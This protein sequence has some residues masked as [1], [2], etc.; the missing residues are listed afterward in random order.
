MARCKICESITIADLRDKNRWLE[1]HSSL[2]SLKASAK[3]G[4]DFCSLCW[5]SLEQNNSPTEMD[6]H[7]PVDTSVRL[8]GSFNDQYN[9]YHESKIWVS[10]EPGQGVPSR[11]RPLVSGSLSLFAVTGQSTFID[12]CP[13][14]FVFSSKTRKLTSIRLSC[15]KLS[16]W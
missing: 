3:Q 11:I 9:N 8:Q 15:V 16:K 2:L 1:I 4:C 10:V 14:P 7:L 12:R 13:F 5:T 6:L